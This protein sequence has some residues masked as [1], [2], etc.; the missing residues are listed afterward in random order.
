MSLVQGGPLVPDA[1][2]V[3]VSGDK[4]PFSLPTEPHDGVRVVRLGEPVLEEAGTGLISYRSLVDILA[5]TNASNAV[6]ALVSPDTRFQA[7]VSPRDLFL[8]Y[9]RLRYA[10]TGRFGGDLALW[11]GCSRGKQWNVLMFGTSI[12]RGHDLSGVSSSVMVEALMRSPAAYRSR[13][14]QRRMLR[15]PHVELAGAGALDALVVVI[16]QGED[17]LTTRGVFTDVARVLQQVGGP[18]IG[19]APGLCPP[20]QG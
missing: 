18:A 20:R 14:L 16:M 4:F 10:H 19:P 9:G 17:D 2:L 15:C 12:F 7:G 11:L 6:V 3:L 8:E 1:T 5:V 13:P